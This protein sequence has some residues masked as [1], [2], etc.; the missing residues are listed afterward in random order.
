MKNLPHNEIIFAHIGNPNHL[1]LRVRS[2]DNQYYF[3]YAEEGMHYKNVGQLS[4]TLLSTE[5][6]GGFTG[7]TL[8]M[9]AQGSGYADF[10]YFDYVEQ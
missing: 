10:A 2:G 3:D 1:K 7:V 5:V 9:Y 6:V 4:S 8:G